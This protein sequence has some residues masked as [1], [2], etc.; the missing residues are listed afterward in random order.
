MMRRIFAVALLVASVAQAHEAP[1]GMA[2]SAYCCNGNSTHGDCMPIP[3]SSVKVV[4]GG[5]QITLVPGDHHMVV[6]EHVFFKP[7]S[8]VQESTDGSYHAC[9]FP[10]ENTLRCF[11]APPMSY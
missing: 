5:Y 11:Y 10:D 9:L 3:A 2:Y 1:S 8:E 4:A 6:H 7:Y